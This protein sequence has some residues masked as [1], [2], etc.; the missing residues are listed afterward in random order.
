MP[1]GLEIVF[2]TPW[3]TGVS[4]GV[5][6]NFIEFLLS[7]V[8]LQTYTHDDVLIWVEDHPIR[9]QKTIDIETTWN[10]EYPKV[11]FSWKRRVRATLFCMKASYDSI[12]KFCYRQYKKIYA[13][14]FSEISPLWG[15]S[16]VKS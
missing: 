6:Y 4:V 5:S 15:V 10:L 3:S 1:F 13:L 8:G 11:I 7:K 9:V 14:F 16:R 2:I 12:A